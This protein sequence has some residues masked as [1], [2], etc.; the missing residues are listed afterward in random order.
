MSNRDRQHAPPGSVVLDV[1]DWA[2][3]KT[4]ARESIEEH[5]WCPICETTIGNGSVRHDDTCPLFEEKDR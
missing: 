3:I 2:V 5:G 1:G 4:A